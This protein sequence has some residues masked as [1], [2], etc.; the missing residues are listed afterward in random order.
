MDGRVKAGN[1]DLRIPG[2]RND[3]YCH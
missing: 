1:D 3:D 2:D